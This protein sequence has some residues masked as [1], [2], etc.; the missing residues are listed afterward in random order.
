[1]KA[2]WI[3]GFLA[4]MLALSPIQP[5]AAAEEQAIEDEIIYDVLVDRYFNKQIQ[6]DYEVDA[7]DPAVF[8]GGDF[9][10]IVDQLLHVKEMGFTLLS[11][12]PVFASD[13]YDGKQVLD[14]T[15]LERHFGTEEELKNLIKEVHEQDLKVMVDVPTQNVSK[16]HI[17]ATENP[18]WFTGNE[19]G[20]LS[21]DTANPEVQE[22]LILA[23]SEFINQYDVDGLRLQDADRLDSGFIEDFSKAMKDIR[24]IYLIND[25]EMK[26]APGLDAVVLPGAEEVLRNS[27][28]QFDRDTSKMP[29]VLKESEGNLIRMDSLRSSRFIADVVE[30]RGFPPTRM[31]L[32]LTQLLTMPGIPVIQYGTETVMNGA[33][34][35]ESHQILDLAVDEEMID[36]ITNLNTLRNSSP[37]LRSGETEVLIEEDGWIV[38]KRFNDKETWIVAINNTSSTKSINL[39]ADVIGSDKELQGLFESDRVRQEA[40]GEYRISM[41]REIAETFHVTEETGFNKA[42]IAALAVVYLVFMVFLWIVWRKGKQ[43]KADEAAKK[44]R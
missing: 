39:P 23:L 24:D 17:W 10:G 20:T 30:E 37:A 22:A 44:L 42:Y 1:M 32:M 5:A 40:N 18:K 43:R 11:I 13:T 41:D 19:D 9:A 34:L 25:V 21:L 31:R 26:P 3:L 6:N 33:T 2:K 7:L 8:N 27:Y 14:Y 15:Q 4:G 28:K 16:D 36:H 35:P 29:A 38:Y 12:G